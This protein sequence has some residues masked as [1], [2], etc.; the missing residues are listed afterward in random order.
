MFR[1]R[2]GG[3]LQKRFGDSSA[4]AGVALSGVRL[5]LP[6]FLVVFMTGFLRRNENS[7]VGVKVCDELIAARL[8]GHMG[9]RA[10]HS[11]A[12]SGAV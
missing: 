7:N 12:Q 3:G 1:C 6:V 11:G 8:G 9:S 10:W 2:S 5:S 4:R